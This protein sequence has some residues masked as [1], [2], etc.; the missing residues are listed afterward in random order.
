[1]APVNALPV[2]SPIELSLT[3]VPRGG[4]LTL[5]LRDV[6]DPDG[7]I[8][9]VKFY[10]DANGDGIP[11]SS[12][13]FRIV[14]TTSSNNYGSSFTVPL[15]VPTGQIAFL[16]VVTDNTGASIITPPAY[17]TVTNI[18]PS[19]GSL[20]SLTSFFGQGDFVTLSASGAVDPDGTI[21]QIRFYIDANNDGVADPDELLGYSTDAS[22][23]FRFTIT[24]E[25]SRAIEVGQA[26]FLAVAVDN[27]GG[28]SNP[29]PLSMNV[30]FSLLPV[31]APPF[32]V[33]LAQTIG[34][35]CHDQPGW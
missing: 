8:R 12:E 11:D 3:E 19:V 35:C 34:Y 4:T 31:T 6:I 23:N 26:T 13:L 9:N 20:T 18:R 7:S 25:Q 22:N 27:D 29:R 2:F 28:V 10:F 14:N 21:T 15:N 30:V 16:A 5:V 17:I 1:M 32:A 24:R 33:P